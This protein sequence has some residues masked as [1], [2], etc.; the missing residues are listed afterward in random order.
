MQP[1]QRGVWSVTA[2]VWMS[3]VTLMNESHH[4][5]EWVTSHVWMGHVPHMTESCRTCEWVMSHTHFLISCSPKATAAKLYIL[6]G[7][8]VQRWPL[9]LQPRQVWVISHI[10]I[11]HVT[12]MTEKR[13]ICEW[14]LSHTYNCTRI[15]LQLQQVWVMS[16]MWIS[17]VTRMSESCHICEWAMSHT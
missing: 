8:E 6:N 2:L 5:Y 3:H 11:I 4:M 16:H 7:S 15:M 13:H 10:W 12:R 17:H 9:V 14:A 1:Q